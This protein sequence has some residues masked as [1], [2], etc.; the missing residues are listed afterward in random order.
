MCLFFSGTGFDTRKYAIVIKAI[1]GGKIL[2]TD[3]VL[4]GDLTTSFKNNLI[5][6]TNKEAIKR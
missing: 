1:L 2:E 4:P 6:T 5:W 3:A